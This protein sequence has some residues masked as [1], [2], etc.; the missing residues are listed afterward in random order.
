MRQ[1]LETHSDEGGYIA[2]APL[3]NETRQRASRNPHMITFLIYPFKEAARKTKMGKATLKRACEGGAS[4][5]CRTKRLLCCGTPLSKTSHQVNKP[6]VG[7]PGGER[8][9]FSL[10]ACR[11]C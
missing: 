7:L 11:F 4:L 9:Y 3:M 2:K 10:P 8:G 5:S 6:M 1:S